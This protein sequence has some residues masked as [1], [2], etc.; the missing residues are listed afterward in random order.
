M[1][2]TIVHPWP[3]GPYPQSELT[4]RLSRLHNALHDTCN[5]SRHTKVSDHILHVFMKRQLY[6]SM[7]LRI[8]IYGVCAR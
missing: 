3:A 4:D 5:S 8:S 1:A 7:A 2:E 6:F